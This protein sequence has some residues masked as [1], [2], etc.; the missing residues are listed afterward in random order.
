MASR[1]ND[2]RSLATE[3]GTRRRILEAGRELFA[4]RGFAA[5]SM[6]ELAERA[7]VALSASYYHFPSKR[8]VLLAIMEEAMDHLEQGALE[9][10]ALERPPLE[11]LPA[12]VHAH[13][14]VH[15]A[16]PNRARVAD[17]EI[18]SLDPKARTEVVARR[19]RYEFYFRDT[20]RQG[21]EDGCFDSSL[22]VTV[23][24]MAI[25]TMGTAT[26]EWW[27][28]DGRLSIDET[29]VLLSAL[30]VAMAVHGGAAVD[31]RRT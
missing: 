11:R 28:P 13:V 20:L 4:E 23:V 14:R 2:K 7:E 9:V 19:D 6:R 12:L 1:T 24:A 29:A 8:D 26:V 3:P 10:L 25:I 18:R 21:I 15:L 5:S 31:S 22:D 17:T 16:E 27:R 30:A